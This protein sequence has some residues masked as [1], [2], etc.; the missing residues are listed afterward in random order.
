MVKD[1]EILGSEPPGVI[2]DATMTA[3]RQWRFQPAKVKGE[4]V[5]CWC[6]SAIK[7]ELDI[8]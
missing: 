7:Y 8:E 5:A 6:Q 2:D 3:V 4:A 1:V